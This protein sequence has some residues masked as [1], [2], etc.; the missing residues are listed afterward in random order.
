[1]RFPTYAHWAPVLGSDTMTLPW[2]VCAAQ[3]ENAQ[4]VEMLVTD[5]VSRSIATQ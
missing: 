1:V 2:E 4:I 3:R 5:A